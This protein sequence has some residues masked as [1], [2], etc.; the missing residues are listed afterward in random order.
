MELLTPSVPGPV[1]IRDLFSGLSSFRRGSYQRDHKEV[2]ASQQLPEVSEEAGGKIHVAVGR[3]KEDKAVA[4]LQWVCRTFGNS[5]ICI[6]HVHQPS[7]LIPTLLGRLPASQANPEVVSAFRNEERELMRKHLNSY[8]KICCRL[9]V[10]ASIITIEADQI[11]KG[12]VDMVNEHNITKLVIG[13]IPDCMKAKKISRKASYA[14]KNA[15][16]FCKI[17]FVNKGKLVFTR[18]IPEFSDSVVGQSPISLSQPTTS[19]I[20]RSQSLRLP[21]NEIIVLPESFRS[22]SA[23]HILPAGIEN[24]TH[25]KEIEL[26][27]AS[28]VIQ[29][30]SG[31]PNACTSS[32][33]YSTRSSSTSSGYTSSAEQRLSPDSYTTSGEENLNEQLREIKLESES[34]RNELLAEILKCNRLEAE[35]GEAM[36]KAK[37]WECAHVRE[38]ELRKEAERALRTTIEEQE[39]HLEER[40]EI[41]CKLQMAMRNIALLDSRAQEANNR[42]EEVAGELKLIQ[43]SI[44]TLRKEKQK[45][46]QQK[47]E[48]AHWLNRWRSSG[49]AK[50]VN[51]NGAINFRVDSSELVEFSFS[52][53]QIATC[54]FSESFKIGEG[55]YGGVYKGELLDRSVAIKKLH[56]HYM[57]RQ[58]E[59][60]QQVQILGKLHHPHLVTLLG[61]CPEEWS[62]IYEY[63]PG[64]NLQDRLLH[65]NN[66]GSI[67][68]KIRS[69]IVAEIAEGLLF[70][71][72]SNPEKIVHGNLKPENILLGSDNSCK[73]CDFGISKLVPNQT[74]RC[75]SFRRLSVPKGVFSYTDPEF[76]VTGTLTPKSDI[77]SF[78]LIILQILTGRTPAELYSEVRRAVSCGKLE[79][80]LDSSA[81]EWSLYVARRLADLGLNC[82]ERKS[83]DRPELTPTLVRELEQLHTLEERA[84]PSFFL[85][86]IFQE[87]MYDPQVAADGFTY[88]GEAIRGWLESGRDTSPMTN[89]KL[90]HLELTPNHSLRLAIQDWLCKL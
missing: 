14:A 5:E 81:G 70:L 84:V 79:S 31:T 8:M 22:G 63:I 33:V 87:L 39:K 6:L 71:H 88:E 4:L 56:P 78:G 36:R 49:K 65:K 13:A 80:I 32:T 45:L 50:G 90:S 19:N 27:V 72:S 64:G 68:W 3:K 9:K 17:M 62:L 24:L 47:D 30:D 54:D 89:L 60:L 16:S 58:S 37:A 69:R 23:R 83:R 2:M 53:L 40:E 59:F 41:S 29:L 34:S 11:H 25:V 28:S 42:C 1:G 57:Q 52:D 85:C 67:S 75:P 74:L 76:H 38:V 43:N 73:I 26:D 86:P 44:A 7:P 48:A 18:Q 61:I 20:I 55:G 82:C 21:K 77:Y 10:K 35:A 46:Q 51:T 15:P 12:I 66:I